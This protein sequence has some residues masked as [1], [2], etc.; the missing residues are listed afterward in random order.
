MRLHL[1][2][3]RPM[4]ARNGVKRYLASRT[5]KHVDAE[6]RQPLPYID[7]FLGQILNLK[8]NW[9]P[10]HKFHKNAKVVVLGI[11]SQYKQNA[12]PL[13]TTL[14][15]AIDRAM[16]LLGCPEYSILLRHLD[17]TFKGPYAIPG[18]LGVFAIPATNGMSLISTTTS[19]SKSKAHFRIL[20]TRSA[21]I[22]F[23]VVLFR[24]QSHVQIRNRAILWSWKCRNFSRS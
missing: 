11:H 7:I 13:F 10:A 9:S 15:K 5:A 14:T 12:S 21:V 2:I 23:K 4:F 16:S 3:L 22:I 19:L 8:R 24:E 6:L 1:H 17:E 20:Q 18:T